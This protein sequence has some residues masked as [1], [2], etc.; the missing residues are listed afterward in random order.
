MQVRKQLTA[1]CLSKLGDR[2]GQVTQLLR[3]HHGGQELQHTIEELN[4]GTGLLGRQEA[5]APLSSVMEKP[6]TKLTA[7]PIFHVLNKGLTAKVKGIGAVGDQPLYCPRNLR[8]KDRRD[9]VK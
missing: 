7:N 4:N 5:Q 1:P 8:N 9:V 2:P 6:A 3:G